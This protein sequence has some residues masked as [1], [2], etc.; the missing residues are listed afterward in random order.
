MSL[1]HSVVTVH[2]F[3]GKSLEMEHRFL[4]GEEINAKY[5]YIL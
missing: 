2:D 4:I 3:G 5:D 1:V